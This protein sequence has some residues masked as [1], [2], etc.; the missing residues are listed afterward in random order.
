MITFAVIWSPSRHWGQ[1]GSSRCPGC[2]WPASRGWRWGR[3]PG[4]RSGLSSTGGGH[5]PE[6]CQYWWLSSLIDSPDPSV[7]AVAQQGSGS[8]EPDDRFRLRVRDGQM[9]HEGRAH[10]H[11][12][13]CDH[14]DQRWSV[15]SQCLCGLRGTECE[16]CAVCRGLRWW[17]LACTWHSD[18]LRCYTTETQPRLQTLPGHS[19]LSLCGAPYTHLQAWEQLTFRVF[20]KSKILNL[21][22]KYILLSDLFYG[23]LLLYIL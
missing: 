23:R 6:D 19:L 1:W 3:W 10:Q 13:E 22:W 16:Y 20:K 4:L 15:M 9:W 18:V 17:L 8:E 7:S 21:R 11:S 5:T 12:A 2:W 14:P